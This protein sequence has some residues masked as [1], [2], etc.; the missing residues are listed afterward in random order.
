MTTV[1]CASL[2]AYADKDGHCQKEDERYDRVFPS[3]EPVGF[4]FETD[5]S[6][7]AF[8]GAPLQW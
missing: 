4:I 1:P 7:P 8:A 6:S 5:P 3:R 2:P